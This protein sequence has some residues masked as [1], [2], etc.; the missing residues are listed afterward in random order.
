MNGNNL[1]LTAYL[2][3][4]VIISLKTNFVKYKNVDINIADSIKEKGNGY[5][6]IQKSGRII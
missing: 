4:G 1:L 2:F 3:N 6:R 5:G